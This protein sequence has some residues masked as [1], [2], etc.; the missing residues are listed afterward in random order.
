MPNHPGPVQRSH[1]QRIYIGV[2]RLD[3]DW[4]AQQ[5]QEAG[6]RCLRAAGPAGTGE[7]VFVPAHDYGRARMVVDRLRRHLEPEV[8]ARCAGLIR[9]FEGRDAL[10]VEK[11][12]LR[13]RVRSISV[14]FRG[15]FVWTEVRE[16]PVDSLPPPAHFVAAGGGTRPLA[17]RI[18]A[19]PF[20]RAS[21]QIWKAGYGAWT[22]F[23]A[24]KVIE[25]VL[26]RAAGLDPAL[27][28]GRRWQALVTGITERPLDDAHVPLFPAS[29]PAR[30]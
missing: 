5:L 4:V 19:G 2:S 12:V 18:G 26:A 25:L 28:P 14:D 20:T 29:G 10:Y 30:P 17:W 8:L 13:V 7:A 16:S 9:H 23:T 1:A 24:P 3:A 11:G 22:I 15:R 6:V 21:S 27:P